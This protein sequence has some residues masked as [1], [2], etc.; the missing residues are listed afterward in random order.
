MREDAHG[1]LPPMS[2]E[3]DAEMERQMVSAYVAEAETWRSALQ[4]IAS[5]DLKR[6]SAGWLQGIA[7][8][9]LNLP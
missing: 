7:R 5:A 8:K 9:A 6:T 1:L 3:D 4:Q 2:V